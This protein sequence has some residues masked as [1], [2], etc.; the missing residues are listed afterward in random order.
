MKKI[1]P[2]PSFAR[3]TAE[4]RNQSSHWFQKFTEG[5]NSWRVSTMGL[6]NIGRSE[7]S[8][9]HPAVWAWSSPQRWDFA[10]R[11]SEVRGVKKRFIKTCETLNILFE[12]T[13]CSSSKDSLK[14]GLPS[15]VEE[16]I[17]PVIEPRKVKLKVPSVADQW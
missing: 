8:E 1:S 7:G 16:F 9:N 15:D 4:R 14:E 11:S 17:L 2:N 12:Q 10:P 5:W 6:M 13:T 3:S